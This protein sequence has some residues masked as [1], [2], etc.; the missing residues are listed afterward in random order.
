MRISLKSS[1]VLKKT[2]HQIES[3]H[4][5]VEYDSGAVVFQTDDQISVVL[6]GEVYY[7]LADNDKPICP[8]NRVLKHICQVVGIEGFAEKVEGKYN[9]A[10]VDRAK[11]AVS[12]F[13]D[14]FNR[15]NLFYCRDHPVASTNLEDI[16]SYRQ[17]I[18]YDPRVLYCLL[19]LGYPP[20]G[21]TPYYRAC[22]LAI[23]ERLLMENGKID[24]IKAEAKPLLSHEMGDAELQQYGEIL[25]NAIMCRSSVNEDWVESSGGWDSTIILGVLRRYLKSPVRAVFCALNLSDG[26]CFNPFEAKKVLAIGQYYD[27]PVEVAP[28]SLGRVELAKLWAETSEARHSHFIGEWMP[29]YYAMAKA[30]KEKGQNGGSVFIGSFADSV[31][32]FGFSQLLSLPYLTY[33]FRDYSDKMRSYLYSPSFLEKVINNTFGDDFIYKLFK[34]QHPQVKFTHPKEE[35]RTFEYL[36]SFVLSSSRLPFASIANQS[37]FTPDGQAY[38]KEW[39]YQNY[40]KEAVEQINCQNMYFWLIWLYQHFHLQGGERNNV[41]ASLAGSGKRVCQPYYDLKLVKFLQTMPESWG[42]GLEWRSTKYPLKHY[43]RER[44]GIPYQIIKTPFH[45]YI[46]Q[47]EDGRGN[48]RWEL[49]QALSFSTDLEVFDKNW[50]NIDS[51]TQ[52]LKGDKSDPK[53]LLNL[54]GILNLEEG[55]R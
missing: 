45:S 14:A 6:E 42:R 31:H 25:E 27:I 30:I 33:D 16:L 53:L 55:A 36:L 9:V 50:F 47:T 15:V 43:G 2:E 13:G 38:F 51:L 44:L 8:N 32:N 29:L 18:E 20:S 11:D 54:I 10:V 12:I 17:A 28:L 26:R 21:H 7:C 1:D 48:Y 40:F 22:R 5:R 35:E 34:W 46:H 52:L 24:V 19:I 37:I 23:G 3:S 41:E 4:W 49:A 39:L